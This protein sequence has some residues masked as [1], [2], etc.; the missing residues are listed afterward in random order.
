[1]PT[2]LPFTTQPTPR[3]GWG[4]IEFHN[5]ASQKGAAT[6]SLSDSPLPPPF[7]RKIGWV[8]ILRVSITAAHILSR[9]NIPLSLLC[10]II[11]SELPPWASG[12]NDWLACPSKPMCLTTYQPPPS[13]AG[14]KGEIKDWAGVLSAAGGGGA[15]LIVSFEE[16]DDCWL[17]SIPTHTPMKVETSD[18]R[19]I[20]GGQLGKLGRT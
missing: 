13:R 5:G 17:W 19:V 6:H 2:T 18:G 3:D 12:C 20:R 7:R 1:M 4:F 16:V 14:S 15:P 11:T 8:Y 9:C 10:V